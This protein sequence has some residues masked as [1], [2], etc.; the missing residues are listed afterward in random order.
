[1]TARSRVV[2]AAGA[3]LATS[4]LIGGIIASVGN[5]PHSTHHGHPATQTSGSSASPVAPQPTP[6]SSLPGGWQP[7]SPATTVPSDS[8]VQQQYDQG[9]EQGFSSAANRAQLAEIETLSLP[10]P[11]ITGSWPALPP[12]YTPEGWTRQ[13]VAGLLDVDFARQSRSGLGAWLV[14]EEAPDLMPGIPV[15]A[16]LGSLYAT[17]MDPA[18][19]GQPS[20]I[21]PAAIWQANAAAGVRWSVSNLEV[22]LDPA[23]QSMIDA[24]WQPVDLYASVEDVSGTLTITHGS[25]SAHRTF[26]MV[27]QLGSAHWHPGY[28]TALVSGWKES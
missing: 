15:G 5:R 9:F 26:S 22:Q 18:I 16:Q 2:L 13:F 21:P 10:A 17:V 4:I 23:W 28:G 24:G 7:V 20:P 12:A 14:A 25:S 3:L 19:T 6:S 11:A 8:P 27:V 1:M